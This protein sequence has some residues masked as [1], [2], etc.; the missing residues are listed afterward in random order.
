MASNHRPE[1]VKSASDSSQ[2]PAREQPVSHRS[3][4]AGRLDGLNRSERCILSSA[5]SSKVKEVSPVCLEG[6]DLS[7]PLS[8]LRTGSS[9]YGFHKGSLHRCHPCSI[10][11]EFGWVRYLDD[12]LI[13]GS[14]RTEVLGSLELVLQTCQQLGGSSKHE[15]VRS[16]T[17]P[18]TNVLGNGT[19]TLGTSGLTRQRR[20]FSS[21]R[22]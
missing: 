13:L 16:D 9:P 7:V 19:K 14:T 4:E 3:R 5:G 2:I 15:K 6:S 20:G 10:L 8:L 12:W 17:I 22:V 1:E 11:K 18:G 21:S